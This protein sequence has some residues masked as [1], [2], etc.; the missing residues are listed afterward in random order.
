MNVMRYFC[1]S[2]GRPLPERE[3]I[4][5]ISLS[6]GQLWG[7]HLDCFDDDPMSSITLPW[8]KRAQEINARGPRRVM[9]LAN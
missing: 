3:R 7:W 2:C 5:H 4:E 1:A 6:A 9:N 8:A